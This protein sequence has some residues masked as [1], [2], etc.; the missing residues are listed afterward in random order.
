[1]W[2]ESEVERGALVLNLRV[3]ELDSKEHPREEYERVI[4]WAIAEGHTRIILNLSQLKSTNHSWGL[5]QLIFI[6]NRRLKETGGKLALCGLRRDPRRV[7]LTSNL[8]K[9][10][11]S[12]KNVKKAIAAMATTW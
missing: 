10:F 6:A 2:I 1:M 12:Y 8:D 3:S 5:L 9:R 4:D 7:L 11:P